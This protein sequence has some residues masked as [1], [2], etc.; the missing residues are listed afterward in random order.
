MRSIILFRW[1]YAL[2]SV[3]ACISVQVAASRT[4]VN[5]PPWFMPV[6]SHTNCN[7]TVVYS[8]CF[9]SPLLSFRIM[10]EQTTYTTYLKVGNCAFWNNKT[11][12]II[13]GACPYILPE[14]LIENQLFKLPQNVNELNSIMCKNLTREVGQSM[15]GSCTDGTGPSVTSSSSQ[16]VQ[17]RAV[18]ALYYIL[19][20]YLPATI[21]FAVILLAQINV[22]S[23]PMAHYILYCNTILLVLRRKTDFLTVVKSP[24]Q[25]ILRLFLSLYSIWSF[26]PLYFL[27]PPLCFTTQIKDIDV[28]YIEMLATLYPFFLLLLAYVAI[29]LH[30]RDFKPVVYIWRPLHQSFIC[31]RRCYNPRASLVQAFA[32]TFFISY[33]KLLFIVFIPFQQTDFVNYNGTVSKNFSLTYID[34]TVPFGKGKHVYLMAF[35][36][37]IFLV[38]ILPPILV[39]ITYPTQLFRRLQNKLYTRV[40]LA[41]DTFVSTLQGCFKNGLNGTRDY[42]ALSGGILAFG[43]VVILVESVSGTVANSDNS[44]PIIQW[45]IGI[46]LVVGL[47]V[48][49]AVLRP[50]KSDA[51]NRVLMCLLALLIISG[52]LSLFVV[53]HVSKHNVNW[54]TSIAL[55]VVSIPHCVLYGYVV[56]R[57]WTKIARVC[58][59]CCRSDAR[60]SE[61]DELL[62]NN[63]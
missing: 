35:S 56:Y 40:N 17:C 27:S 31:W 50:Y 1:V 3:F 33:A 63:Q 26:E 32:T 5:C 58:K 42:R 43:V 34:L 36:A 60:D 14:H 24:Y 30:A 6:D 53:N 11:G 21:I 2:V 62:Y 25:Y 22:T 13:V 48:V 39:L 37:I 18:S 8:N 45:Q 61:E 59:K 47:T 28:L 41:I 29:E 16:C 55:M 49:V 10:C 44:Q 15:C 4:D 7:S 52:T 12:H 57:S 9:C 46:I 23:T 54:M 51:G 19:L 20:R 38:I